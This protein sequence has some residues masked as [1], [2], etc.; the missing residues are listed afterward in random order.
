MLNVTYLI[1]F[2]SCVQNNE[3]VHTFV[4]TQSWYLMTGHWGQETLKMFD[5]NF[6]SKEPNVGALYAYIDMPY[7]F[8][9]RLCIQKISSLRKAT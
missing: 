7:T 4:R 8:S 6:Y 3:H 2:L 9:N 1:H 5:S